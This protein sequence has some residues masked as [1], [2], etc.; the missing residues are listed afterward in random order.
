[1]NVGTHTFN[2]DAYIN[3]YLTN[4]EKTFS[5]EGKRA[6]AAMIGAGYAKPISSGKYQGMYYISNKYNE[7][8]NKNAA[9]IYD[10]STG[11]LFYGFIGDIPEAW[12]ERTTNWL[13]LNNPADVH[14]TYK[15]KEG[16][17]IPQHQM[18]GGFSFN[19]II[20]NDRNKDLAARAGS[21]DQ[22]AIKAEKAREREMLGEK[23]ALNPDNGFSKYDILR[24][25]AIGADLTSMVVSLC[26]GNVGAAGVGAAG[27]TAN[28]IADLEDG[29]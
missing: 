2:Y 24:L 7:D 25:S 3:D 13:N 18:G 14:E 16:G 22:K 12:N 27:T 6:V 29:F 20:E 10:D 9:L 23:T 5:D 1:M 19:N 26:G 15:F 11:K 17:Q 8:N 28:F 4:P 21:N